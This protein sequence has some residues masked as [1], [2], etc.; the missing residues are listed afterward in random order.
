[1]KARAVP[2]A[3]NGST[4]WEIQT[5]FSLFGFHIYWVTETYAHNQEQAEKLV[6]HLNSPNIQP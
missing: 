1:M 4:M 6:K 2:M 5:S 3:C